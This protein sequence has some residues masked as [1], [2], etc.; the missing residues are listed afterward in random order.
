MKI[1]RPS[2]DASITCD[3]KQIEVVFSNIL[4]NS[5]QAMENSGE[6]KIR[7]T[8]NDENVSIEIEDSGPGIPED[9][10]E[11]IFEPLFT[12]KSSGT[13]LGL[14]SSKN[15]V[16]QHNG[17]ITVKNNPTNFEIKLP[18]KLTNS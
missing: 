14:V 16:E 7:I 17:T 8:E 13:G 15:I 18:K 4:L 9:K 2:N 5:V 3:T 6:I 10:I 1:T 11:Q 12:T